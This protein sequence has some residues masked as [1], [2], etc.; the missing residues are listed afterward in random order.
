MHIAAEVGRLCFCFLFAGVEVV[1]ILK[2]N[3]SNHWSYYARNRVAHW[4]RAILGMLGTELPTTERANSDSD[5]KNM[6]GT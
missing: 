2:L 5:N 4:R 3:V 1:V 6:E